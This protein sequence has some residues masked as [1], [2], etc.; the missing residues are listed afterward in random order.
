MQHTSV[1]LH[2]YR[3][4]QN[5]LSNVLDQHGLPDQ[6]QSHV[7]DS[8]DLGDSGDFPH[9]RECRSAVLLNDH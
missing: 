3:M 1:P 4:L 7:S 2:A 8:S 6:L 9:Q 5:N